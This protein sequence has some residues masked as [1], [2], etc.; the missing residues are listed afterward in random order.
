[1]NEFRKLMEC[2]DGI[3]EADVLDEREGDRQFTNYD[4]WYVA[5]I[6][7]G[8]KVVVIGPDNLK[9]INTNDYSDAGEWNRGAGWLV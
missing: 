4:D 6:T 8:Y 5:A 2:L 9:A 1:M 3:K 7:G